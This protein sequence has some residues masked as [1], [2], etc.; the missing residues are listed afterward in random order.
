MRVAATAML[1]AA[2]TAANAK[3]APTLDG[4]YVE[5]LLLERF[6]QRCAGQLPASAPSVARQR[7]SWEQ[8]N[9]DA[10]RQVRE[11]VALQRE[12]RGEE[13]A[14]REAAAKQSIDLAY[15]ATTK[16]VG[17]EAFCND[18]TR[19]LPSNS[20]ERAVSLPEA[21]GYFRQRMFLVEAMTAS[22]GK[23]FPAMAAQI[24]AANA[25]WNEREAPIVAATHK[26]FASLRADDAQATARL[27][28][29]ARTTTRTQMES[30]ATG[31]EGEKTC[32]RTIA[33]VATGTWRQDKPQAYQLLSSGTTSN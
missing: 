1:L 12:Q 30:S 10:V 16:L 20:E 7:A 21:A 28:D 27:E 9:A 6:E 4:V 23:H 25:A 26:A 33:D 15:D 32:R 14:K 19:H 8:A 29:I 31:P 2:A 24:A 5:M 17:A 11:A 3:S 18:I 13:F 22:C